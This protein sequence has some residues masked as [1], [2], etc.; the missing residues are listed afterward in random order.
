[1]TTTRTIITNPERLKEHH[2]DAI[3][4]VVYDD[5]ESW[6]RYLILD[7]KKVCDGLRRIRTQTSRRRW[8]IYPEWY[9][10]YRGPGYGYAHEAYRVA[11]QSRRFVVYCQTGGLDI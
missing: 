7:R 6:R 4:M 9:P 1:M 8:Y 5:G 11:K 10:Y 2:P 3:R